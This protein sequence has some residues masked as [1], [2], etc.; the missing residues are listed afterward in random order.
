M[1]PPPDYGVRTGVKWCDR[2]GFQVSGFF[3]IIVELS[4]CP[5]PYTLIDG[6]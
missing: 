6:L 2:D 5:A 3:L 4:N 1:A